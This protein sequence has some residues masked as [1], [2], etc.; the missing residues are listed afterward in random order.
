MRGDQL[1]GLAAPVLAKVIGHPYWTGLTDGTLPGAALTHF[2]EQDTN[3]LLPT[4]GR[5]FAAAA[6][7]AT[8]DRHTKLLA[9]CAFATIESAPRLRGQLADIAADL[10]IG[11]PSEHAQADPTTI[12]YCA[13]GQAAA[14]NGLAASLGAV[15]PFLWFHLEVCDALLSKADPASTYQPWI[16]IYRPPPIVWQVLDSMLGVVDDLDPSWSAAQS[17]V[18]AEHFG[19]AARYEL[20]FAEAGWRAAA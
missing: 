9:E 7:H 10:G 1:R 2:V 18:L 8:D 16:A 12:A 6:A 15:L 14:A 19:F 13:F 3:H 5:L 20:A 4:F 17:S 11:P